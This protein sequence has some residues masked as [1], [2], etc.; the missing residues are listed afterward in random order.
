MVSD[1]SS[2]TAHTHQSAYATAINA[3]SPNGASILAITNATTCLGYTLAGFL[4]DRV[5]I[6]MAVMATTTVASIVCVT[7]WGFATNGVILCMFAVLWGVSGGS[8]A[9][10]WGKMI[11]I[12]ARDDPPA[13][14]ISYS[15]FLALKGIGSLTSGPISDALL[16]YPA[17]QGA[18]GAYGSTT[19]G[20]LLIYTAVLTFVGGLV[21]IAFPRK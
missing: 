13:T 16:K 10:Y 8:L 18:S 15:T 19:Y 4:S 11:T 2:A 20:A 1:Y 14:I 17:F 3:T 21:L 7:L 6:R 5:S 12:I 9:G